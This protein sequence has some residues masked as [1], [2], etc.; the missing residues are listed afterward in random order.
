M[1]P[2][3]LV[4]GVLRD[5][6]ILG[7]GDRVLDVDRAPPRREPLEGELAL[8]ELD[9]PVSRSRDEGVHVR[10]DVLGTRLREHHLA[11]VPDGHAP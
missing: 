7:L 4:Q 11:E 8:L 3:V 9:R 5:G 10:L 1:E 2:V 6:T